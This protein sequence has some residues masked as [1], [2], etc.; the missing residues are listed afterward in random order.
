[1]FVNLEPDYDAQSGVS[2]SINTPKEISPLT[3]RRGKLLWRELLFSYGTMTIAYD[4]SHR[5]HSQPR[6]QL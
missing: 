3:K 6:P 5:V 1:M 4:K 2:N